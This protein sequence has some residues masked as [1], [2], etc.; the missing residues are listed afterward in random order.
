MTF[1]DLIPS[2]MKTANSEQYRWLSAALK[3]HG[4]VYD[5]TLDELVETGEKIERQ[6]LGCLWAAKDADGTLCFYT[7]K[8][9]RIMSA[10]VWS[11]PVLRVIFDPHVTKRFERLKWE[12]EPWEFNLVRVG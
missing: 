2:L 1:I 4:L 7:A 12:N 9:I 6:T 5:Q 8:P 10:S 3:Q 11:G